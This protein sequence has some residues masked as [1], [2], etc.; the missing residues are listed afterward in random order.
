MRYA[1]LTSPMRYHR[2]MNTRRLTEVITFSI[3]LC[4]QPLWCSGGCAVPVNTV[5]LRVRSLLGMVWMLID[6]SF[7]E[8]FN[9]E[10][11]LNIK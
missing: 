8:S 9:F 7:C 11:T 3:Y 6:Y 1:V 2:Q 5:G 4:E 10:L